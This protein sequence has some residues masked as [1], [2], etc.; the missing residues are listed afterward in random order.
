MKL[1]TR[2]AAPLN[3]IDEL[4][5][6]EAETKAAYE[7]KVVAVA[8]LQERMNNPLR[9]DTVQSLAE[10]DEKLRIASRDLVLLKRDYETAAAVLAQAEQDDAAEQ[11]RRRREDLQRRLDELVGTLPEQYRH[12]ANKLLALVAAAHRLD[13]EIEQFNKQ[14]PPGVDRLKTFEQR[15]R[16]PAQNERGVIPFIPVK[17]A[18][19]FEV[20]ALQAGDC[21]RVPGTFRPGGSLTSLSHD[22]TGRPRNA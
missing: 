9:A 7:E 20:A 12:H 6:K 16:W 8:G 17:L 15:V 14:Q 21:F 1:Q 2:A 10:I 11:D 18:D 13:Q 22:A 19:E 4:R 5:A 3:A